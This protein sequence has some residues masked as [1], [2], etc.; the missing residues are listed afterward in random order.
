MHSRWDNAHTPR[1]LHPVPRGRCDR[2]ARP[3][4]SPAPTRG[5]AGGAPP[6]RVNNPQNTNGKLLKWRCCEILWVTSSLGGLSSYRG[7]PPPDGGRIAPGRR[8][9]SLSHYIHSATVT[10]SSLRQTHTASYQEFLP[11]Y[12]PQRPSMARD[13][14]RGGT[15][16]SG[17]STAEAAECCK[18]RR[19]LPPCWFCFSSH[20][21]PRSLGLRLAES[22]TPGRDVACTALG[23]PC[24]ARSTP[25]SLESGGKMS[26]NGGRGVAA[27]GKQLSHCV[28]QFHP[29]PG[30]V[31]PPSLAPCMD[32]LS[33]TQPLLP[34]L[35]QAPEDRSLPSRFPSFLPHD[36][37]LR[38]DA[39]R[40]LRHASPKNTRQGSLA[41]RSP[42]AQHFTSF[43]PL[44][45]QRLNLALRVSNNW[46]RSDRRSHPT[47]SSLQGHDGPQATT[48]VPTPS[49]LSP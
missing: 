12:R 33:A 14:P 41:T 19:G 25:R 36:K 46:P 43:I 16:S 5:T 11:S 49:P 10:S 2:P 26:I 42:A 27:A 38:G 1:V 34:K 30:D 22:A 48:T 4:P 40:A 45:S 39:Q 6:Y 9:A 17:G 15:A 18:A 7:S 21:P 3:A 32:D 44:F 31:P 8:Y 37:F 28:E 47:A 29:S 35:C 13:A 24:T 23:I 20:L